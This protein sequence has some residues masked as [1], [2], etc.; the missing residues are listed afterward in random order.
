VAVLEASL[1]ETLKISLTLGGGPHQNL[2][3]QSHSLD[4]ALVDAPNIPLRPEENILISFFYF[5][6]IFTIPPQ[7]GRMSIFINGFVL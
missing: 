6:T 7:N 1:T 5:K 3:L 4:A 2:S